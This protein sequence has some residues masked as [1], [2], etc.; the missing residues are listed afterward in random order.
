MKEETSGDQD[1]KGRV[2]V[3]TGS[4]NYFAN[5]NELK[6]LIES[7]G[8]K[9]TGSVTSKTSYL[10]NNDLLSGSSKNKKAKDLGVEIISEQ[11][12]LDRFS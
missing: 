8:G 7:K 11:D 12:F 6:E 1:L 4:L 10:I 5:R 3:V 9:V 2:F